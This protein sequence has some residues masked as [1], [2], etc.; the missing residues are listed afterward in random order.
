MVVVVA[1]FQLYLCSVVFAQFNRGKKFS[2]GLL[3]N[4]CPS[5]ICL[6]LVTL[7]NNTF[8]EMYKRVHSI[9]YQVLLLLAHFQLQHSTHR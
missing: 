4:Q 3:A 8:E 1:V 9:A 7:T 2:C 5:V 6:Y